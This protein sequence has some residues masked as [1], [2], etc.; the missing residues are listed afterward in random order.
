[1]LDVKFYRLRNGSFAR[2]L[3]PWFLPFSQKFAVFF[4]IFAVIFCC[5]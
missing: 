4:A 3:M 5:P 2:N 1:M